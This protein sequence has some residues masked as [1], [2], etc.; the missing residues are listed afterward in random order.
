M[1]Q[2]AV[3]RATLVLDP[4]VLVTQNSTYVRRKKSRSNRE[5]FDWEALALAKD[6]FRAISGPSPEF[7]SWTPGRQQTCPTARGWVRLGPCSR[8][9][10]IGAST[11]LS[12]EQTFE[13]LSFL[14]ILPTPRT[15]PPR[16]P[17]PNVQSRVFSDC[18]ADAD[19][20][21]DATTAESV[22]A[23]AQNRVDCTAAMIAPAQ[24]RIRTS[25]NNLIIE[26]D[27]ENDALFRRTRRDTLSLFEMNEQLQAVSATLGSQAST[28][29]MQQDIISNITAAT[30]VALSQ[31]LSQQVSDGIT[32]S[33]GAIQTALSSFNDRVDNLW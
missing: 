22:L 5:F 7:T 33:N 23:S 30:G 6:R 29:A 17:A 24:P 19:T 3:G 32:T 1:H 20:S 15:R 31:A 12:P 14:T 10:A 4:V 18:L 16:R 2:T 8:T 28:F 27:A 9:G 26:V 13:V 11:L 25:R 21:I